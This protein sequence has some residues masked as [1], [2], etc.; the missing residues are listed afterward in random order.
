LW[1]GG[2]RRTWPKAPLAKRRRA[3]AAAAA[4]QVASD[5]R[6]FH[7][8]TNAV[9]AFFFWV[10]SWALPGIGMF[11]EAYFIF[12]IGNLKVRPASG[13]APRCCKVCCEV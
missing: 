5:A 13:S 3:A 1:A 10:K 8:H 2:S 11:C 4:A 6:R 9:T 12:S 7:E